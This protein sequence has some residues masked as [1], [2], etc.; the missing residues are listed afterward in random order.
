M[1]R[2]FVATVAAVAALLLV[3][4]SSHQ[5]APTATTSADPWRSDV[6]RAMSKA[7][8]PFERQVLQDGVISRAEYEEAIRRYVACMKAHGVNMG[9]EMTALGYYQ[10]NSVGYDQA[11]DDRCNVGTK[12]MIEPLYVDRL[13]N[14]NKADMRALEVA[15]FVRKGLA[16]QGYTV[17][18]WKVDRLSQKPPFS[19]NDPR[20]TA[21]LASPAAQ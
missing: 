4:C 6:L 10:Y 3:G 11:V 19:T 8:S 20:F 12:A 5:A 7:T 2:Q 15:C 21:C 13:Q 14:P 18:Q 9:A 16:A 17:A 1:R